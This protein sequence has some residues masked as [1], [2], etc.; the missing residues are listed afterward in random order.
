M[1]ISRVRRATVNDISEWMP[2]AD[3]SNTMN[4]ISQATEVSAQFDRGLPAPHLGERLHV[5]QP[6]RRIDVGGN[7]AQARWRTR[8]DRARAR[9][10]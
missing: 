10:G 1:P 3:S 9:R 7:R 6:D 8:P 5:G 4:E 2:V